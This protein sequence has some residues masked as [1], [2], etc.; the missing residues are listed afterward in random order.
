MG[1]CITS[2]NPAPTFTQ[3]QFTST[4]YG[5]SYPSVYTNPSLVGAQQ[6]PTNKQFSVLKSHIT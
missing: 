6:L 3:P 5:A 2:K 4:Q 1:N